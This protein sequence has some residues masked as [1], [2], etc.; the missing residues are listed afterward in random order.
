MTIPASW[1][2]SSAS[3]NAGNCVEVRGDLGAVRDSKNPSGLTLLIGREAME[4]L[5]RRLR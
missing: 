1:R 4:E 2:K 3:A 5:V